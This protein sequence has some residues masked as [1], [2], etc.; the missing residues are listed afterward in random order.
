LSA[1]RDKPASQSVGEL[2]LLSASIS[3][4]IGCALEEWKG[5]LMAVVNGAS[6][7][8]CGKQKSPELV[9]AH[10]FI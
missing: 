8:Q 7:Q 6:L 1:S 2:T 5:G 9:E 4:T 3:Q 10:I